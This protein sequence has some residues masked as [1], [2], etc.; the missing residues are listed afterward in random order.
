MYPALATNGY[1]LSKEYVLNKFVDAGLE[2]V[3]ISIDGINSETHDSFRGVKGSLGQ[4]H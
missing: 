2:F 1:M 4:S 3:Q